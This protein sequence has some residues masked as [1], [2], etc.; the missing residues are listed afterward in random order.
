MVAMVKA[1]VRGFAELEARY[2]KLILDKDPRGGM[3]IISPIGWEIKWM[4]SIPSLPGVPKKK[5][6]VNRDM[7]EPLLRA[8]SAVAVLCPDYVIKRIGCWSVRY[9][10]TAARKVSLHAYGLAVD[11]N[12]ETNPLSKTLVTDMPGEFVEAFKREGFVWGGDF[13]GTKDAMHF[14]YASG[15]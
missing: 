15:Y 2:G 3:R 13:S 5:L 1:P 7:K 11:I 6:Y 4:T 12:P 14:Q 9:K 8:L 10:A